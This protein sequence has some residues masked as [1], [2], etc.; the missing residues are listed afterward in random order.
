MG[1]REEAPTRERDQDKKNQ[2]E[3]KNKVMVSE[4]K[5]SCQV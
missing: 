5:S 4:K 2:T 1:I 3:M